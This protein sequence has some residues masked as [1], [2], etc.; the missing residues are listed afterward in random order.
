MSLL[1]FAHFWTIAL[2]TAL[3]VVGGYLVVFNLEHLGSDFTRLMLS[4]YMLIFGVIGL[5]CE[6]RLQAVL[7]RFAFLSAFLGKAVFYCFCGTMGVAF[8]CSSDFHQWAPFVCGC[9]SFGTGATWIVLSCCATNDQSSGS[10]A[11]LD[12]NGT[13]GGGKG[14][15]AA[16][17]AQYSGPSAI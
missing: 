7:R 8:G 17:T 2:S 13:A 5:L 1:V 14:S 16:A 3:A 15:G 10:Y 6:L 11:A 12:G 4:I 9:L